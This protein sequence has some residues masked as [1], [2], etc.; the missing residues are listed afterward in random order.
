M[1]FRF[2]RFSSPRSAEAAL[3]GWPFAPALYTLI[4]AAFLAGASALLRPSSATSP[5]LRPNTNPRHSER[6]LRS[7]ESLFAIPFLRSCG[8]RRFCRKPQDLN[9]RFPQRLSTKFSICGGSLQSVPLV[10]AAPKLRAARA[11][12]Y[13]TNLTASVANRPIGIGSSCGAATNTHRTSG[14]IARQH[15]RTRSK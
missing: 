9:H 3:S 5:P 15:I 11:R 7:E 8:R 6:T 13:T 4:A 1:L 2:N 12:R 10:L 14:N